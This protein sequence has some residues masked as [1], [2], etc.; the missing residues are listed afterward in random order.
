[1]VKRHNLRHG[2]RH[3]QKTWSKT[4][5]KDIVR[6]LDQGHGQSGNNSGVEPYDEMM[7]ITFWWLSQ[8]SGKTRVL[9]IS[10]MR[11]IKTVTK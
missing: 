7:F 5:S 3:G 9:V 11:G 2:I 1:M 8:V 4:W 10:F 6:R